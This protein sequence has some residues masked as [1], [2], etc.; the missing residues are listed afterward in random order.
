MASR[1]Y[2]FALQMGQIPLIA[3]GRIPAVKRRKVLGNIVFWIGLFA[4][5]SSPSM[6]CVYQPNRR[7][8]LP[9][10]LRRVLRILK[11]RI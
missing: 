9:S 3:I 11:A 10:S 7:T 8:R 4:G 5:K 6:S 1:F 2:L